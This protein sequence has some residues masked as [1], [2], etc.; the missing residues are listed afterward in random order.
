VKTLAMNTMQT[1]AIRDEELYVR[2]RALAVTMRRSIA[3]CVREA[4][5]VWVATEEKRRV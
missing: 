2:L 4:V 5:S 1:M 3:S